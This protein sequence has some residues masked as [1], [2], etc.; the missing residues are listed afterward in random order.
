MKR[1]MY[2]RIL[3]VIFSILISILTINRMNATVGLP[4]YGKDLTILVLLFVLIIYV[5][6]RYRYTNANGKLQT[7]SICFTLFALPTIINN[8]TEVDDLYGYLSV[9]FVPLGIAVGKRF[10][11]IYSNDP[12]QDLILLLLVLPAIIGCVWGL[13]T[14]KSFDLFSMG[15]DYVFSSVIFF[16]LLCCLKSSLLKYGLFLIVLYVVVISTKRTALI[17]VCVSIFL[18]IITHLNEIKKAR[19]K[20]VFISIIIIASFI[21]FVQSLISGSTKEALDI[22]I[23]RMSNL[24]DNS[25]EDRKN[26]YAIIYSK[27]ENSSLVSIAFGH[28]YNAVTKDVLGHPAHNDYLEITYDYGLIS[29]ICYVLI[30]LGILRLFLFNRRIL[31]AD[32]S[33]LII[34]LVIFLILNM[35]NCF[36]T[37]ALYVYVCMFSIGWSLEYTETKKMQYEKQRIS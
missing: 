15:R 31:L 20:S 21:F 19:L 27:I 9:L 37:N 26:I 32:N 2:N 11:S 18:Y 6:K 3:I 17:A 22:T 16:P 12:K 28:G 5:L 13:T 14:A 24:N 33:L 25:N 10:Y 8:T 30:L 23:E 34:T 36:I 29:T 1:V 4:N 7:I 35:A